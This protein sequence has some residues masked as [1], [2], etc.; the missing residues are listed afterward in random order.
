[1]GKDWRE[2]KVC[3]KFSN[4]REHLQGAKVMVSFQNVFVT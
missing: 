3:F 1:M 2:V 4:L